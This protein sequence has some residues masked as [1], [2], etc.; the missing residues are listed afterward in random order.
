MVV[1][2]RLTLAQQEYSALLKL[3]LSNL[4]NPE[5]QLR[6]LLIQELTRLG[7]LSDQD[8]PT[9]ATEAAESES[10]SSAQ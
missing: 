1:R 9:S 3:A 8:A 2:I 4:R 10:A 6:F 5:E 7:L